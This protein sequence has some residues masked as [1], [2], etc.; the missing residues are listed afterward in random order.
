MRLHGKS[1]TVGGATLALVQ[2]LALSGV[3]AAELEAVR[4]DY[5]APA[6]CPNGA[7]FLRSIKDRTTRFR[8]ATVTES[9]RSF[10]ARVS[11]S[12]SSFSG[13]LEIVGSDNQT[14]VRTVNSPICSEVS[15]ALALMTAL[16]IDPTAPTA[17]TAPN[18]PNALASKSNPRGAAPR[19]AAEAEQ[20]PP[21]FPSTEAASSRLAPEASTGPSPWRWSAGVQGHTTFTV[22]PGVGYGGDVFLDAEAP[23]S[24]VL[25]PAVRAGVF[26]NQAIVELPSGPTA[27]F[28]WMVPGIEGCPVR[29]RA[30]AMRLAVHPCVAFRIGV[31]YGEGQ[32]MTR[33]KHATSLWADVGP[34]LRLRLEVASRVSIEA[35]GALILPLYRPT[36]TILDNGSN[37]DAFSVPGIGGSVGIGVSYRFP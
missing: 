32:S 16:A 26:L 31:L 35:Q 8:Q 27:R 5:T 17:P 37:T 28:T 13:R 18:A 9:A 36:F 15:S 2:L 33:A 11:A 6:A 4:I 14:A 3:A 22:T 30:M 29:L 12:G 25:G 24:S 21:S 10:V 7:A 23:D 20:K 19:L 34:L 1:E